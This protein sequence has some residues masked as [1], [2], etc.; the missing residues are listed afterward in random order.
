MYFQT[1]KTAL[2]RSQHIHIFA[3]LGG[4][5]VLHRTVGCLGAVI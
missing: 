5:G 2:L 4:V 3:T 1:K